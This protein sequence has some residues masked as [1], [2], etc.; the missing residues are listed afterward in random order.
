[1]KIYVLRQYLPL[2]V[3]LS[4]CVLGHTQSRKFDIHTIAFYNV[5]NLF[6]TIDDRYKYDNDFTPNGLHQYTTK[7]YRDKIAKISSVLADIG[8]TEN[9]KPPTIIGLCEVETAAV[10]EDL[11]DHKL[12]KKQNYG[13][14]HYDSPDE[15]GIDVA[16]LYQKKHFKKLRHQVYAP[17]LFDLN[18]QRDYTRDQLVVSGQL[19]GEL[20]LIHI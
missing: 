19:D 8:R 2:I 12:L 1:M 10:L 17:Q 3:L 16:L 6:D 15:R 9:P 4:F 20:S 5:E 18:G 7:I 11:V 14:V 13:I